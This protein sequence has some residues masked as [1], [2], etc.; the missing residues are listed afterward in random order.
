MNNLSPA[1]KTPTWKISCRKTLLQKD[2]D[3]KTVRNAVWTK[4]N[5]IP[6]QHKQRFAG[7]PVVFSR[8]RSRTAPARSSHLENVYMNSL[9]SNRHK[10]NLCLAGW[11]KMLR[12]IHSWVCT[13]RIDN[14]FMCYVVFFEFTP[15]EF[16]FHSF[17][18]R[19]SNSRKLFKEYEK[20]FR[21][22][23][24]EFS[25]NMRRTDP[26]PTKA[27]GKRQIRDNLHKLPVETDLRVHTGCYL[28]AYTRKNR[29][30]NVNSR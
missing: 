7:Y 4:W 2:E 3:V 27:N 20:N 30:R 8:K 17:F 16:D 12:S 28:L 23:K 21:R 25:R 9:W 26:K 29:A 13:L 5:E 22:V 11:G 18:A 19:W 14:D 15:L 10:C 6:S 1:G 24:E